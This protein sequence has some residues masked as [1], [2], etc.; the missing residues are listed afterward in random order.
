MK[1]HRAIFDLAMRRFRL[2]PGEALFIDDRA[3][4]VAGAEAVGLIGHLF[5]GA[6]NLRARLQSMGLLDR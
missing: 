1:P 2:A 3:E 5:D 4:N 6:P